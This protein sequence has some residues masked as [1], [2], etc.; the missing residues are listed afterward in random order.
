MNKNVGPFLHRLPCLI[1]D[2]SSK[3]EEGDSPESAADSFSSSFFFLFHS[4]G[5]AN[6]QSRRANKS[7]LVFSLLLNLP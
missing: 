4:D 6:S 3:R 1:G 5:Q 7:F 2:Y